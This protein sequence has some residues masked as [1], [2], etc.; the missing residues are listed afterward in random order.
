MS[1]GGYNP[2]YFKNHPEACQEPGVLY[3]V[4]LVNKK[5]FEREAVKIGITKGTN[6]RDAIKRSL[7]FK[8][9]EIRIQ[10]LVYGPLEDIF[11]LEQYLHELWS[12]EKYKP[13]ERFGG[14][15]ECFNISA[16]SEILKTVPAEV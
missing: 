2:T 5:T 7:G 15:T 16:L 11:Y 8:G 6:F 12:E 14:W 13:K 3:C 10:K 1:I 4:V 9:Y